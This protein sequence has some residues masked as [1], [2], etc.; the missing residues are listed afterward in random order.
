M[1]DDD[2][3]QK[4][5]WL[6]EILRITAYPSGEY[7][8][9]EA[10]LSEVVG[11]PSE[12]EVRDSRAMVFEAIG[13]VGADQ[14]QDILRLHLEPRRITWRR[15]SGLPEESAGW[16]G[17]GPLD[18]ALPAFLDLMRNWLSEVDCDFSRLALGAIVR[19]PVESAVA[20]YRE[21]SNYLPFDLDTDASDLLYR[22]NR[23]RPSEALADGTLVNRLQTWSVLHAEIVRLSAGG[24]LSAELTRPESPWYFA[25]LEM[26]I[27]TSAERDVPI[28]RD[29]RIAV[30]EEFVELG[31][32]IAAHG[33][34]A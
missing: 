9:G 1:P 19:R 8:G 26:D 7:E 27:N 33:D 14:P 21:L 6:V 17:I 4:E 12:R 16:A 30:I 23:A 2:G 24:G 31:L 3:G 20:G 11:E 29:R 34:I 25:R 32:E 15:E 13:R 22:I 5:P 18:T 10:W 28:P